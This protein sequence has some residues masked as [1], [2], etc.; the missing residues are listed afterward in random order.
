MAMASP[1]GYER[2]GLIS[3]ESF[4]VYI[5]LL[6][7]WTQDEVKQRFRWSR[8]LAVHRLAVEWVAEVGHCEVSRNDFKIIQTRQARCVSWLNYLYG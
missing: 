4:G 3:I 5:Q 8:C 6:E 1:R 7:W 2:S